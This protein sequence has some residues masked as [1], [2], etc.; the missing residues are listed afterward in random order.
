MSSVALIPVILGIIGLIAAFVVY[1]SVLAYSAG[2]GK[3]SQIGD[4]I[5]DG[6]L[7]FMRREYTYLGV[8]VI[9]V[10]AAIFFSDL[11]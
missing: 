7:V 10:G 5:H 3:V 9:V 6:A 2:T 4:Q 8:F 1:R 11:G